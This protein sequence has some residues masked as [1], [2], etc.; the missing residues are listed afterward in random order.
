MQDGKVVAMYLAGLFGGAGFGAL[1]NNLG[2]GIMFSYAVVG[3][4]VTVWLITD[5]LDTALR[6]KYGKPD[7]DSKGTNA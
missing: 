5:L 7:G 6:A 2:L 3:L 1:T 4:I